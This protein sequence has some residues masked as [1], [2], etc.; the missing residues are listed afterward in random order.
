MSKMI[1]IRTLYQ[2]AAFPAL[3]KE[4]GLKNP[5][6]VPKITKVVINVGIGRMLKNSKH[7][8]EVVDTLATITGQQPVMTKAKKAIAGFKTRKGLEVGVRVTLHGEKMWS[9]LDRL[10]HIALPR[11]RDFQGITPASIDQNG[12][13]NIGIKEQVIFPEVSPEKIQQMFGFQINIVTTAKNR[14]EAEH[15]FRAIGMPLQSS[16]QQ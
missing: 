2:T 7:V 15:M 14:A 3:K 8:D 12:N 9:F 5:M 4:F 10:F 1:N 13:A 6:A 16:N 11:T